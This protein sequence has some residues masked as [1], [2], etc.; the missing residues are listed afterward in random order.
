MK[1]AVLLLGGLLLFTFVM[2]GFTATLLQAAAL[3]EDR[4]KRTETWRSWK[5]YD[6]ES[7]IL[8]GTLAVVGGSFFIAMAVNP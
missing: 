6:R 1:H 5:R 2:V 8:L 4:H 7:A 3:A